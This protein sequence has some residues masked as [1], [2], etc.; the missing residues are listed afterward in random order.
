MEAWQ[1]NEDWSE[2]ELTNGS[3]VGFVYLFQF[4]DNTSYIGSKQMYKRVK[5]IKKL[6]DSSIENGWREYSSSSKIVNSKI[7]EGLNY[8]RTILWAF[9]TMKETLFVET[10]LI[11]NEGLKT[12]NLNLAVMHKA[13]LPSGKDAVRIR[14]IL[15]SLYEILN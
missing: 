8:T 14:G 2:E 15:Q 5:D 11:I 7:Q 6:K 9:P 10:A 1:Y 13:R 12:G 3:Y 4:E